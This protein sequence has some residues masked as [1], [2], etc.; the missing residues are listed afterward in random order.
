MS[1]S[2]FSI[3]AKLRYEHFPKAC[4]NHHNI[5]DYDGKSVDECA[6][7]CF[8]HDSCVAFE[9]RVD[10]G[11]SKIKP[12]GHCSLQSNSDR[13]GCDGTEWNMDLYVKKGK[14]RNSTNVL[15]LVLFT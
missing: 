9:Y 15:E 2:I 10:H 7:L 8:I 1:Y 14:K 3:L 12:D 11:G 13:S 4:V 5:E 6:S